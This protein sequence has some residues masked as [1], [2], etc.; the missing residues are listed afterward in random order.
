MPPTTVHPPGKKGNFSAKRT[1]LDHP[2]FQVEGEDQGQVAV[3]CE[4][5]GGEKGVY[6]L[7]VLFLPAALAPSACK[8][9]P[10]TCISQG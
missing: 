6:L 4:A 1:G 2:S 3:R 10:N 8:R 9:N 5:R 7:A